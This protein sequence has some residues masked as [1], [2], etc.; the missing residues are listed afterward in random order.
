[1]AI[2]SSILAWRILWTGECGGLLS[3]GPHRVGHDWI[4]LAAAAAEVVPLSPNTEPRH[5]MDSRLSPRVLLCPLIVWAIAKEPYQFSCC[6]HVL[7]CKRRHSLSTSFRGRK[8]KESHIYWALVTSCV[9]PSAITPD[10]YNA[11]FSIHLTVQT[12]NSGSVRLVCVLV[13]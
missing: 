9:F 13:T 1:M 5:R 12:R 6:L 3:I 10:C 7:I 4:D 8:G 2:H 11:H